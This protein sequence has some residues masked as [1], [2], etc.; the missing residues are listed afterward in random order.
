MHHIL[1]GAACLGLVAI[2]LGMWYQVQILNQ[3]N[4]SLQ[5]KI[6]SISIP[7]PSCTA[8]D[9]WQ[10]DTTQTFETLTKDGVRSYSVHLPKNFNVSTYYPLI[11]HFPGKGASVTGGEQQAGLNILNA[12]IVYPHPTIGKDGYNSWEG[13]PYSSGV[14]DV[15][16]TDT[17]LD[18]VQAQ[19]C[20]DR[21]HVY[22]TGMSNGGGMVSLLSCKLPDRFAAFGIVAGAMYYPAGACTPPR[23]TPLINIH[24]DSDSSVPYG[25]STIRKLPN[26]A[27]WSADRAHD[28]GC[29]PQP[30]TT[31]IDAVTT[32]TSWNNCRNNASVQNIKLRGGG[33]LW[34]PEATQTLWQ[35]MSR[36]SL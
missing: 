13:A 9:T 1:W 31:S 10:Q 35:F 4:N 18:K 17:V 33:H 29:N 30:T 2:L 14:D 21:A 25:G 34:W 28:N 11:V 20:V 12:I 27:S 23:P 8:R 6:T 32:I 16:F 22:A 15:A 7:D 3:K 36:H 24:G 26:I 5:G 19:L